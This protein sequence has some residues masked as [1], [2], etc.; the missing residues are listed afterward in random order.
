MSKNWQNPFLQQNLF[1]PKLG[2]KDPNWPQNRVFWIFWRILSFVFLGNN[3]KWKLILLIFHDQ[4][5]IWQNSGS[6]VMDQNAC[7]PI[8]LQ[9]SLKCNISRIKW[10]IKFIFGMQINIEVFYRLIL[11]FWVCATRHSQSTR[12]VFM[13]LQYLQR[14]MGDEVDFLPTNKQE[15]FLQGDSIT[16]GLISQACPNYTKQ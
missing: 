15:S 9:N 8:K 12:Y 14:S 13:S 11:S 5:Y 16:L 6:E 2:Q 10:M 1:F 4:S 7:Q 3:L